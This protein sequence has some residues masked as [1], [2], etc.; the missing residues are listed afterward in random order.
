WLHRV[1]N[2]TGKEP[3]WFF[4]QEKNSFQ[5][6]LQYLHYFLCESHYDVFVC[7]V[8][9]IYAVHSIQSGIVGKKYWIEKTPHNE[10]NVQKLHSL[11]PKAKF[12]NVVRNPLTN[13]TSFKKLSE[14]R[15]WKTTS[16]EYIYL[17]KKLWHAAKRNQEILG[18]DRYLIVSYEDLISQTRKI[19]NGICT[20]LDIPFHETML[21]PT[22]NSHPATA[23]SVFK[24]N[25]VKGEILDQSDSKR[26]LKNLSKGEL[27]DI[28]T[29]LYDDAI[30]F[31]YNWNDQDI[32]CYKRTKIV[33]LLLIFLRFLAS[34]GKRIYAKVMRHLRR[35][36]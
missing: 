6:F 19:L 24:E 27:Q 29:I 11:F 31:G 1:I 28:V 14:M 13:I 5:F 17:I 18:E 21:V 12:V 10:L 9:S 20:F 3:F 7:V 35:E 2:P 34:F 15:G 33:Q 30:D 23:N 4:G 22:E 26:Y 8:M 32:K 16:L 36:T 25:M